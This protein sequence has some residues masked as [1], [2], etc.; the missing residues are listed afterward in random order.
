MAGAALVPAE[1]DPLSKPSGPSV[2]VRAFFTGVTAMSYKVC[3]ALCALHVPMGAVREA[4]CHGGGD[5]EA[6]QIGADPRGIAC[7]L[8]LLLRLFHCG[9]VG[10]HVVTA[11]LS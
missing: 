10:G 9:C 5:G 6:N 7:R 2:A 8:G 11:A 4:A 1:Y 3:V